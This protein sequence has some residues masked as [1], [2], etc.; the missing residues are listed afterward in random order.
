ML[1]TAPTKPPTAAK[2]T[3]PGGRRH[4]IVKGDTLFSLAQRYY[5]NRSKWRDIYDANRDQLSSENSLRIGMELKI[6]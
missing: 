4:T 3:S 1:R 5:G 6:P 2:P